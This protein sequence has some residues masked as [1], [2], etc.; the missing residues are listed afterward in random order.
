MRTA[1][2]G[3]ICVILVAVGIL[4]QGE[5][6]ANGQLPT[7][8]DKVDPTVLA[9]A[10]AGET[11]FLVWLDAQAVAP[12]GSAFY[13]VAPIGCDGVAGVSGGETAVFNFELQ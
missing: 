13:Q 12:G 10:Q 6:V 8:R 7:W 4:V 5:D 1:F 9:E 3:V 11:V 2:F